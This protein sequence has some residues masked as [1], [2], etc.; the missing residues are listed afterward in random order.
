MSL[1]WAL[2][3]FGVAVAA[4][5]LGAAIVGRILSVQLRMNSPDVTQYSPA[6]QEALSQEF[7]QAWMFAQ[8]LPW[9]LAGGLIALAAAVALLALRAQRAGSASV[10][11]ASRDA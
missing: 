5:G 1:R 11:T 4:L 7:S 10:A 8:Q 6:E 3:A 9:F 2:A